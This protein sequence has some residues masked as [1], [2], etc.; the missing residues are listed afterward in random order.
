LKILYAAAEALP[1]FKTGGLADVSRAL[2][3]A[4]L[5][6]GHDV[7]L[8]HP[9]YRAM[10]LAGRLTSEMLLSV[11]WR[12]GTARTEILLDAPGGATAPAALVRQPALFEATA[13]YADAPGDPFGQ[14][15]RF[16]FFSRAVVA[17]ARAWGADVV[18]VN[19]WHTGLVPLFA[20]VDA[21]DAPTVF[22]IHNLAYQGNFAPALLPALGV[23][24]DMFR[25]ENG[26]EFFGSASFMKAGITFADRLVTV[27]PTYARQIQT[28][29]HGAGFDGLLR[30]RR[31]LL[32]GILNGIDR[33]AWNPARDAFLPA[34]YHARSL[35]GKEECRRAVFAEF[36]L[37]DDGPLFV[38]ISRLVHQKGIDVLLHA[39][40]ELVSL[41]ASVVV[42]GDGDPAVERGLAAAARRFDGRIA[43]AAAFDEPLAHRLYA[44]ADFLVMPSRYEPCGL[45]QMIAQRYGTPPLATRTGGLADTIEDGRT[46]FL[47]DEPQPAA[48][49]EAARR[50]TAVWRSDAWPTLQRRCMRLDRSWQRAAEAYER[51]YDLAS[52]SVATRL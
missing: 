5:A 21:L 27:S 44:G 24:L 2:P 20:L 41:G 13:P 9:Y 36:G 12:D 52:G 10:P 33:D 19:D 26:V 11:P 31:R 37:L 30:F 16:A 50:A 29:A 28:P 39:L 15:V 14:A 34:P 42:L 8:L 4:L 43:V 49:V 6:R 25:T 47:F 40:P 38:A 22:A 23:P 46:G 1:Y 45:G 48:L 18:H 32:N 17:Y 51:V 35:A 7:R 3:D